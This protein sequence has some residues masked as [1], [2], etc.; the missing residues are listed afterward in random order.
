[1]IN[2]DNHTKLCTCVVKI[3]LSYNFSSTVTTLDVTAT[4]IADNMSSGMTKASKL[5]EAQF[6]KDDS[7]ESVKVI[8]TAGKQCSTL[9]L[10]I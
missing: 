3:E 1:M 5:V 2:I 10:D 7:V 8:S 4:V 9:F 6:N